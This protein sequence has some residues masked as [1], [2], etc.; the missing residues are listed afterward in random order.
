MDIQNNLMLY[1]DLDS[2]DIDDEISIFTMISICTQFK[3]KIRGIVVSHYYSDLRAKMLLV[4]LKLLNRLNIPIFIGDSIPY[5]KEYN[6][7]YRKKVFTRKRRFSKE[8]FWFT[9]GCV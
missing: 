3:Y 6:Q 2:S 7:E 5:S 1:T 4:I 9:N 8:Y